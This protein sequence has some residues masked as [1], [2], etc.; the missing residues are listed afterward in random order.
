MRNFTVWLVIFV[1][2]VLAAPSAFAG[3]RYTFDQQN[4]KISFEVRHLLG[5]AR[6]EFHNFSGTID[7]DRDQPERSSVSARIEVNSIDTG[8]KKRDEHL[9][10]A[11]FFNGQKFPAITF[12]SQSVKRTGDQSGDV[13]GDLTMRGVTRQIVLHVQSLQADNNQSRWKVTTAPLSRR[14]FGLMF[15]GTTEAVSGIGKEVAVNIEIE[16]RRAR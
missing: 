14:D 4:S 11:E 7:L 8:I 3:E 16:A 15:G 12:K 9:R 2:A 6:G 13:T 5:K 10:S 1:A